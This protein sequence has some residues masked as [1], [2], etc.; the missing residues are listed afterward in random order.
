MQRIKVGVIGVGHLGKYH[1]QRLLELPQ[2][3][4]VG[5]FDR[6]K[7]RGERV[8]TSLGLK[9]WPNL[10]SLLREA[11]AVVVAVP[12]ISHYE[13]VMEAL[14]QGLDV[15]VEKPIARNLDEAEEMVEVAQK[16]KNILQIGHIERF[17][18]AFLSL[19]EMKVKPQFIEGHR[20]S[21]FSPRG[22]DVAV[23]LD[24]MIHDL[25]LVLCLVKSRPQ[26]VEAM[27]VAVISPEEDIANARIDFENGCVANLTASRISA[28][29]MR[30]L[31][32]FQKDSYLSLDFIQRNLELY[33]LL[34]SPGKGDGEK[35]YD[36]GGKSLIRKKLDDRGIDPLREELNSFLR[37]VAS[38][39]PPPVTGRDGLQALKLALKVIEAIRCRT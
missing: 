23:V 4:V 29:S 36:L 38:R 9:A 6:D 35:L 5:L 21:S 20:L 33:R 2:A 19:R 32:I 13:I 7:G 18:P 11:E 14:S 8:A 27:G 28:K 3:Q 31:R 15:L 39:T 26:S 1:L 12:T 16:G 37:S 30:K 22:R 24:L 34:P 10:T 17:N 25:D